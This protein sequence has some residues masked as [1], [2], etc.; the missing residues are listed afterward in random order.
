MI[1]ALSGLHRIILIADNYRVI[2]HLAMSQDGGR[3]S[4]TDRDIECISLEG[5]LLEYESFDV[6]RWNGRSCI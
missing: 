5:L 3:I 2:F 4:A 1:V 6:W